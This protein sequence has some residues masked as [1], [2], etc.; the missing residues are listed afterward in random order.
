[1]PSF[2]ERL[3]AA[4]GPAFLLVLAGAGVWFS[5]RLKF[6]QILHFPAIWKETFGRMF[7]GKDREGKEAIS[8]FQAAATALAGTI[9][10][11][12]IAGV[13]TALVGGGPG[14]VVWMVIS[15]FFSM[16]LKFAEIVL[17]VDI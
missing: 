2:W 1:M 7:S 10:T 6:F 12:N 5:I 14:A 16:A 17:A 11:G 8:P 4:T 15:S 13:A 9:G 3:E